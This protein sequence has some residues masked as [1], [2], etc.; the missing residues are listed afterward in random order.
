MSENI[1]GMSKIAS[2]NIYQ[3]EG[4]YYIYHISW[5]KRFDSQE[6]LWRDKQVF[7]KDVIE[8]AKIVKRCLKRKI[9]KD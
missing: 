3:N 4:K 9:K 1:H 8:I 2:I 7:E 6:G 5:D